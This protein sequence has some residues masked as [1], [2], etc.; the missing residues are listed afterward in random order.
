MLDWG[1]ER[2]QKLAADSS[3]SGSF[4]LG[5]EQS[6]LCADRYEDSA[7]SLRTDRTFDH[8]TGIRRLKLDTFVAA[9][10][11]VRVIL[12]IDGNLRNFGL[13]RGRVRSGRDDAGSG[14]LQQR[15]PKNSHRPATWPIRHGSLS[16]IIR[17]R[18]GPCRNLAREVLMETGQ[19]SETYD[20]RESGLFRERDGPIPPTGVTGSLLGLVSYLLMH[21]LRDKP[22]RPRVSKVRRAIYRADTPGADRMA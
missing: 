19:C 14:D 6:P 13:R 1:A 3:V 5:V 21:L 17:G 9:L 15:A 4:R 11:A 18:T 22:R 8:L 2:A 10:V 20:A 16:L 7:G 12:V